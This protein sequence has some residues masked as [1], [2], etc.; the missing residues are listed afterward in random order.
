MLRE[1]AQR[2]VASAV[3]GEV[4]LELRRGNDYSILDTKSPNLTY[5]PERLTMEKGD[6]V[7]F[8]PADRIGQLTMRNL[9]ISDTR[10]KLGIYGE[11]GLLGDSTTGA[12][13][14]L[15]PAS[16]RSLALQFSFPTQHEELEQRLLRA[17]GSRPLPRPPT[18]VRRSRGGDFLAAVRRQAVHEE[19]VLAAARIM[20]ASTCQSWKSRRRSSFS[21]SKPIEVQTSVV[22]RS[23]PWRRPWGPRRPCDS[24]PLF[25]LV[26]RRRRL[27]LKSN[28]AAACSQVLQ[29]LFE[30]PI[31]ATVRPRIGPVLDVG[32]DVGQDLAGMVLVGEPVDH[33]HA[34]GAGEALDDRLLEGPHHDDVA[35]ARDHLRRVLHRLAPAELR[36]ACRGR[37]RRRPAGACRPRTT[38]ACASRASRR[39][40]P[41]CGPR[42]A[43]SARSA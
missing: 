24:F 8:T 25:D 32:E 15:G 14:L 42:A 12:A 39:S 20:S 38:C 43:S 1:A 34:R 30:S 7:F 11:A 29:T 40:S 13:P 37:S 16:R 23:A 2:W 35:H 41:A 5:K 36:V 33:R 26:A 28:S 18:A 3:S 22:T 31:Q 19:R 6:E 4:T 17:G 27:S 9:D 10:Q 21:S